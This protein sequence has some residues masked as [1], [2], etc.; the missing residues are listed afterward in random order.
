M[1]EIKKSDLPDYAKNSK[2]YEDIS[3]NEIVFVP[4]KFIIYDETIKNFKDYK[5][6]IK[7]YAYFLSKLTNEII[8][9]QNK[10]ENRHNILQFFIKHKDDAFFEEQLNI[11]ENIYMNIKIRGSFIEDYFIDTKEIAIFSIFI[12]ENE[13]CK[14]IIEDGIISTSGC[15]E[16]LNKIKNSINFDV[17]LNKYDLHFSFV[18]DVVFVE[19]YEKDKEYAFSKCKISIKNLTEVF[20]ELLKNMKKSEKLIKSKEIFGISHMAETSKNMFDT[21]SVAILKKDD[22]IF[23]DIDHLFKHH[24]KIEKGITKKNIVEDLKNN[25]RIVYF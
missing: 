20:S 12:F 17:N 14:I 8:E 13:S 18:K 7:S 4:S 9:Y 22:L 23:G 24:K 6:L 3:D 10:P 19:F 11:F 1:E 25:D 21:F 5:R 15:Y 2:M 16:Y